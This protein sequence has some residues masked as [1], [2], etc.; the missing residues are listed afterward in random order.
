MIYRFSV[1]SI[2]SEVSRF[3][4]RNFLDQR[5]KAY[6]WLHINNETIGSLSF[7]NQKSILVT[8]CSFQFYLLKIGFGLYGNKYKCVLLLG[9]DKKYC[10]YTRSSTYCEDLF[11]KVKT[12]SKIIYIRVIIMIVEAAIRGQQMSRAKQSDFS[13]LYEHSTSRQLSPRLSR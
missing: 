7:T 2:I 10:Y 1:C 11:F 6:E 3:M 8:Y 4:Y 12:L 13:E 9:S 5:L